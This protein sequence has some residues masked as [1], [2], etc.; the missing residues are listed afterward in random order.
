MAKRE[1]VTVPLDRELREFVERVAERGDRSVTGA[2]RHLVAQAARRQEL[3]SRITM[4]AIR[5]RQIP[6][7]AYVDKLSEGNQF[8]ARR[9]KTALIALGD[10]RYYWCSVLPD[11]SG[12]PGEAGA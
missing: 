12:L 9:A 6:T 2:I 5:R 10:K 4:V 7:A 8:S 3:L 1:Q 11:E